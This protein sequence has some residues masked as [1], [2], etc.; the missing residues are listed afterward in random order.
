MRVSQELAIIL[1]Q[2]KRKEKEY[3]WLEAAELYKR[4]LGKAGKD[5]IS[6][7]GDLQEKIGYCLNKGRLA[8]RGSREVHEAR[9]TGSGSI[10]SCS[11]TS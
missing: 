10:R 7:R 3:Y 5:N 1:D 2:A 8:G 4:V 9:S 6:Q 11:P